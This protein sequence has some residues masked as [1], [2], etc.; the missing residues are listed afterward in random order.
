MRPKIIGVVALV[1][2]F[3]VNIGNAQVYQPQLYQPTP[4]PRVTAANADWQIRGNP[5]FY[6]GDFYYPTG[7]N[8]F[9]DGNVMKR[10]G[11]FQGAPL[12]VD[13]TL[14]PYSVVYV[15]I[16]RNLMRPY[17]RRRAGPLAGTVGSR[18]PSF[19]IERDVEVSAASGATGIPPASGELGRQAV[20]ERTEPVGTT[21]PAVALWTPP[22]LPDT[23]LADLVPVGARGRGSNTRR[24]TSRDVER[25]ITVIW[26]EFNGSRYDSAGFAVPYEPGQFTKI[27][28]NRGFPVYQKRGDA[29]SEIYIPSVEDG[30]LARYRRR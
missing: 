23:P 22:V 7:P 27:G 4:A 1:L 8:V 16:G 12:Y 29:S 14:E 30:P 28:D 18:T 24:L 26:L 6:A 10:S 15:P 19:P 25:P 17:E 13:A 2:G 11:Q 21:G 5:I 20:F 3:S 9:F